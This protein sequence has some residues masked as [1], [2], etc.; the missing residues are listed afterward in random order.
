MSNHTHL[1]G[2]RPRNPR[3]P[4]PHGGW[5]KAQLWERILALEEKLR[6]ARI[7]ASV[8]AVAADALYVATAGVAEMS[9][10]P[11]SALVNLRSTLQQVRD[12]ATIPDVRTPA[13]R[14]CEPA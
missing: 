6:A 9:Q 4:K 7:H 2:P 3:P 13:Q 8:G 1:L 12:T 5:T 10:R 11:R 14:I